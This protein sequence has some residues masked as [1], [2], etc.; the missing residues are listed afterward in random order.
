MIKSDA[1]QEGEEEEEEEE[2]RRWRTRT[3]ALCALPPWQWDGTRVTS[4]S[5]SPVPS[6]N[7]D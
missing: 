5:N 2:E 1:E 3:C 4:E 6:D 7:E